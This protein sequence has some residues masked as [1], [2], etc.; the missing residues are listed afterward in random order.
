MPTIVINTPQTVRPYKGTTSWWSFR[1]NFNRIATVNG[2][3]AD[4]IKAQ[5]LM[6]SL[7]GSAAEILK[8][9]DEQS[10]TLYQDIWRALSK[11]FG[12]VDEQ[13]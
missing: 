6:I 4:A 11:R 8:D 3:N 1:D 9:I 7:E 12:E 10:P 13:R 2:W 5:H